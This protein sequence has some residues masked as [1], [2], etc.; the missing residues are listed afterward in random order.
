MWPS[1]V[2]AVH[3]YVVRLIEKSQEPKISAELNVNQIDSVPRDQVTRPVQDV[4]FPDLGI[5]FETPNMFAD[6]LVQGYYLDLDL[7]SGLSIRK[8]IE[9][10]NP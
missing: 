8:W 4:V 9:L 1:H 3:D 10:S 7:S 6:F 5:D 2:S